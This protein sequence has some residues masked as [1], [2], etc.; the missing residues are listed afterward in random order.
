MPKSDMSIKYANSHRTK[1]VV[2]K[3]FPMAL[4]LSS[5][6]AAIPAPAQTQPRHEKKIQDKSQIELSLDTVM[7]RINDMQQ[8]LTSI[9]SFREKNLDTAD[10]RRQVLRITQTLDVIRNS[11]SANKVLEYKQLL[12]DQYILQDIH[13]QLEAWR[14]E[15]F[16]FNNDLV[17][18]NAEMT[19]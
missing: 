13:S 10:L 7:R 15:L 19:A 12:I 16:A 4:I 11:L 8:T 14:S 17:K 3:S 18:M 2:G 1:A 6:L 9:T 5:L